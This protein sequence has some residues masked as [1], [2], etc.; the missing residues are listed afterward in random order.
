MNP[1]LAFARITEFAELEYA[2]VTRRATAQGQPERSPPHD[3]F[4]LSYRTGY[5]D[6]MKA[7]EELR[8]LIPNDPP[9]VV[10][11]EVAMRELASAQFDLHLHKARL[12]EA[13]HAHDLSEP[14]DGDGKERLHNTAEAIVTMRGAC[15]RWLRAVTAWNAPCEARDGGGS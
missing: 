4:M 6:G 13:L 12:S 2:E 8:I 5:L 14:G 7:P 1:G 11:D 9:P 3:V 15:D 10:T